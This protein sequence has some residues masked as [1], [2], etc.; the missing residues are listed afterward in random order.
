MSRIG[1]VDGRFQS[2]NVEMLEVTG[3]RFWKPYS[4]AMNSSSA[5]PKAQSEPTPAGMDPNWYEYRAPIDLSNPRL[6]KLAAALGPAYVRVSGTWANSVYFQNSDD[7]ATS[8]APAGF[9][10]VLTRKEWKGVIDFAHAVN[11]EIVTSFATSQGTRD[12]KGVWTPEQA[13]QF[14]GFTKSAGG[15]I[16]AAEFM[17]EPTLAAMGGA[18]KGYDAAAYG[19]DFNAFH[20]FIKSAEPDIILLGP[21]SVGETAATPSSAQSGSGEIRTRDLLAVSGPGIDAFS[22]HHYGPLSQRC[23][24]VPGQ[25]T[26]EAALSEQWL[27]G[28]D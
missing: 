8:T 12:H 4:S 9:G 20:A 22:Y 2:Y 1:T 24:G 14:L 28:T 3:G 27:A 16:A 25:T 21:G 26:P 11:A 10:S 5:Q 23:S 15:Q 6:R 13:R 7:P 17:N 19:R 18:P